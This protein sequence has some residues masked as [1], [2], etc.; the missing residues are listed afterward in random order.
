MF[1]LGQ[2]LTL[3]I[4][5]ILILNTFLSENEDFFQKRESSQEM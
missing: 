4:L 2:N 1:A 3:E 5:Q